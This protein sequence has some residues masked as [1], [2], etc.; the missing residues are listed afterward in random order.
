MNRNKGHEEL[1]VLREIGKKAARTYEKK[2][3]KEAMRK[4]RL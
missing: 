2:K 3:E 4:R 1:E